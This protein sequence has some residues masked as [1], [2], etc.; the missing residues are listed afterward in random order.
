MVAMLFYTGIFLLVIA[1]SIDGLGVVVSY[2]IQKTRV[3]LP[4][5][6]IIMLCSGFTVLLAMT[7]GDAIKTFLS[8]IV[9]EKIGGVILILLGLFTLIN[10]IRAKNNKPL[11][12]ENTTVLTDMKTVLSSPIQAD[13]DKSGIISASEAALLG[14]ALALDAFG[15]GI[16][17]SFLHYSAIV[18]AVL[19]ALMS[20]AF[21]FI[22]LKLGLVL[23]NYKK[24]QHVSF[25][26]SFLLISIGILNLI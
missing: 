10:L 3:P 16:A 17:A 13:L 12:Q 24:M 21:L 2:G 5:I 18:T 20:G 11:E 1:V 6:F 15:A 26:P 4:A 25:L 8:P 23:S 9:S 19:I 7:L 14:I 22:G